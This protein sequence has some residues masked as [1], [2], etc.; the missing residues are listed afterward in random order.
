[1]SWTQRQ[2]LIGHGNYD[3][4]MA[5]E[6]EYFDAANSD[7]EDG[8]W[9]RAD[10]DE[11]E[12][13]RTLPPGDEGVDHSHAGAEAIFHQIYEKCKSGTLI[14]HGYIGC[15]PEK[16]T[17]A[18]SI[19]TFE[20]YRQIH[21]VS[22]RFTI[23]SLGTTL[24]NLHGIPRISDLA[25]QLSTA[26]DA[27]L[28]ILR[29]VD[30]QVNSALNR[31]AD[32]QVQNVCAPCLYKT[33]GEDPLKFS[34]LACMDG[35]NSLKLVDS[36][37]RAGTARLDDRLSTSFRRLTA[38]QVDIFKDEVRESQKVCNDG[39]IAW[40]NVLEVDESD[41]ADLAK[42]V[43]I[44]V[45]RWK[46]AGPEARK[47]M[48]ALFTV[49]GIFLSVC[50]HGHVLVMCDMIRS[51]ELMKYPL[52][53]AKAL[54]DR[55][56][57]D[58]GLGYDIM[59][60][61]FKTLMR[62]SLGAQAV[63]MRMQGVVPAFHGHAHNR[64]CQI[65]WHP[66]YVDGVGLEDFEECERTFSKSNHLATATRFATP[67]HRQQHIDEHFH[68]HDQDKHAS[69]GTFIF[70][71]YRQA[72]EKISSNT[73]QL[74][75]SDKAR[76]AY[77]NLD[78]NII[79]NGYTRKEIAAV[80]S[81]YQTTWTRYL[82]ISETVRRHEEEHNIEQRWEPNSA[83]FKAATVLLS[84]RKYRA[85]VSNLE[86]LV[87]ARLF[88]LTKFGMSGVGYKLR[89]NI[90]KALKTRADAI[91]RALREYNE[92]AASLSPP[93]ERF[94]WAEVINKTS[95]AEFDFLRD[96]RDDVRLQ[97]WAQPARREAQVLYFGIKRA[98]EDIRRANM[99][100]RHLITYM[101]DEHND[102]YRAIASNIIVNP[103][104]AIV[105]ASRWHHATRI[106]ASI[107]IRLAKTSRLTGFSGALFPEY[108]EPDL[109]AEQT[110]D[111]ESDDDLV[112]REL[113]IDEDRLGDFMTHLSTYDDS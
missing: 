4:E 48:F 27:Y 102:Y 62:S 88:E 20:I 82:D 12:A 103:A 113:D 61:F 68:F 90:A 65:G 36:T 44:C 8:I 91:R 13:L 85:A 18:F 53:I 71:N 34:F 2:E 76:V 66:L 64:A 41:A 21:R 80:R 26:Y 77:N 51:G 99:E 15:S 16:P 32:W 31:D 7:T 49:T 5:T 57:A 37:F 54:L 92:A 47:K 94:T 105:L 25:E 30:I 67:F 93:R 29:E 70:N 23:E 107:C 60:A 84:E 22:P 3:I 69:S 63:A 72:L 17:R 101:V 6:P 52:A 109:G 78:E 59:C 55:Y 104:L 74:Q 46:A 86:R 87:V 1:M 58:I 83:E 89:D 96:T 98:K 39:D 75:E 108:E 95:L 42:S 40:L 73:S 111:A 43:N 14:K 19:R 45:E 35:N 38:Q 50:R 110:S 28:Q 97:P 79:H 56:G 33:E 11:E 112:V 81:R 100:I 10:S 24:C 9:Q 106:S